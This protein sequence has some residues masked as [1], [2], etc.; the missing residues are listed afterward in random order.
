MKQHTEAAIAAKVSELWP[1]T[2]PRVLNG[3]KRE[4]SQSGDVVHIKISQMYE[5]PG[6]TFA[7]LRA[8]SDFFETDSINDDRFSEGGCE[9]CDYGSAYGFTLTVRPGKWPV[10]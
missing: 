7:Q 8:L 1:S 10:S 9:T 5:A 2:K 4:V 6:L 3:L